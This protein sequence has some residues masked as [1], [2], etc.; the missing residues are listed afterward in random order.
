MDLA[1]K[2]PCVVFESPPKP[3]HSI[4]ALLLFAYHPITHS[5]PRK[6]LAVQPL[7]EVQKTARSGLKPLPTF[8][9]RASHLNARI[10]DSWPI[11][12]HRNQQPVQ[13]PQAIAFRYV[14]D[15]GDKRQ[16]MYTISLKILDGV[17]GRHKVIENFAPCDQ[18]TV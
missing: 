1:E 17:P 14:Y 12:A 8:S 3:A 9:T 15:A 10:I 4:D 2:T 6:T 7:S 16:K 5:S 13:P 11:P 18:S